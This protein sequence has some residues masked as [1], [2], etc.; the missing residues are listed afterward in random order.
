MA[1]SDLVVRLFTKLGRGPRGAAT[2]DS[3]DESLGVPAPEVSTIELGDELSVF[4][5]GTGTA[6]TLN[7][8]AS[9]VFALADGDTTVADAVSVLARAYGVTAEGIAEDVAA[10]ARLLREAGVLVPAGE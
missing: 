1:K 4:H 9:D 6:L 5:A 7:R 10:A 3:V 8:T 2:V